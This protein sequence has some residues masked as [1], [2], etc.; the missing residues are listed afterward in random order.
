MGPQF[1]N[2][3]KVLTI[4]IEILSTKKFISLTSVSVI[5]YYST[6]LAS[7]IPVFLGLKLFLKLSKICLFARILME[8][9][10]LKVWFSF[11]DTSTWTFCVILT[12]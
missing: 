3:I 11:A 8:P 6:V 4:Q 2:T 1:W 12:H 10:F 7:R 9:Q 5:D